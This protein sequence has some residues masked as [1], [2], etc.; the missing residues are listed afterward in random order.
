MERDGNLY[1][2]AGMVRE[3]KPIT[4]AQAKA[5][6]RQ[7]SEFERK[8]PCCGCYNVQRPSN[9]E[10]CAG[11]RCWYVVNVNFFGCVT[12]CCTALCWPLC[13][14]SDDENNPGLYTCTDL[15]GIKYDIMKVNAEQGTLAWWSYSLFDSTDV[16]EHENSCYCI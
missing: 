13:V 10:C 11:N 6:A 16:D 8:L 4:L 5:N 3:R 1:D 12:Y 14:C 9:A 15:K 7:M 2:F